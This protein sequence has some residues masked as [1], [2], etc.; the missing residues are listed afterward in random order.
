MAKKL[1]QAKAIEMLKNPPHGMA[2]TDKQKQYFTDVATAEPPPLAKMGGWL[3]KY[4]DGG[5]IQPNYNDAQASTGPGYVGTG[6]DTTGR[7][8]SPAWGGQFQ[9]GGFLQP[10]DWRLPQGYKIPNRD[11]STELAASIGG[12]DGE[13]AYL[14]PTFKHGQPLKDPIAEYK[15]TGEHLGG[16]FKTWQEAEKFGEMRH[17]YVE[18][19]QPIPSPY[20]T[21]GEMQMGGQ[22]QQGGWLSNADKW[23]DNIIKSA[24]DKVEAGKKSVGNLLKAGFNKA[25]VEVADTDWGKEKLKNFGRNADPYNYDNLNATAL[26][27]GINASLKNKKEPEREELDQSFATGR[28]T[29]ED[30]VRMD[31]L[32]RYT[33][34]PEKY[35]TLK[36]SQFAPSIGTNSKTQYFNSPQIEGMIEEKFPKTGFKTK[37][38]IEKWAA[39]QAIYKQDPNNPG[40]Y[41]PMKGKGSNYVA[42]IPALGSATYGAGEDEQG[43]YL[44]YSDKWDLNP[45]HGEYAGLHKSSETTA[46]KIG[47]WLVGGDESKDVATKHIGNPTDVYGRIYFDPKTGQRKTIS[48][49]PPSFVQDINSVLP[50][51]LGKKMQ[52]GGSMPGAV[53][54]TYART[55]GAAPSNGKY[56]KKTKASAQNGKEMSFYQNGLDWK[57]NNISRDGSVIKD[58]RGQWA[59]PGEI[60]E[61]NSND[62]TMQGVDYPVLGVSDIGDIKLMQPGEDYKFKG[63]KVT[64]YPKGG[65]LNKYK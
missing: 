5:P 8:Y 21:W 24:V 26:E 2:L 61:I 37:A 40:K 19:G 53:G 9:N 35:G 48:N 52:M 32:N 25:L 54:F 51:A 13:P 62:I 33:G 22:F 7:N 23:G 57:P 55:A 50:S 65:W 27:R 36:P 28:A 31:L 49:T 63:T 1:S 10:N 14:I 29:A 58:D 59:H 64:E 17:T 47:S 30:S 44:S 12:E 16:P 3:E 39:D 41:L 43:P 56:A 4:N 15:K 6:Y 11:S 18:K 34:L 42:V 60:T 38:D 46:D 45:Y 20:K